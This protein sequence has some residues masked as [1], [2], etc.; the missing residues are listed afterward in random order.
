MASDS[1]DIAQLNDRARKVG[2]QIGWNLAFVVAPN[3]E[4]VGVTA[5]PN[6]I[7][8]MGPSRLSDMAA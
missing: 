4:F 5:G 1:Q 6:H 2:Q 3:P 7:F 8:V